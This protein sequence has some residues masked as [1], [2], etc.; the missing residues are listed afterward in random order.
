[1]MMMMMN[2]DHMKIQTRAVSHL[3]GQAVYCGGVCGG[4]VNYASCSLDDAMHRCPTI[5]K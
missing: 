4:T 1:M 2:A 5:R 3:R